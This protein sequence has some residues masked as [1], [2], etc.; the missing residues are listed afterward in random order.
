MGRAGATL[1]ICVEPPDITA[2]L[3]PGTGLTPALLA[4]PAPTA[5]VPGT[6]STTLMRIHALGP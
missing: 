4:P 5:V 3:V 6:V 2:P 1:V